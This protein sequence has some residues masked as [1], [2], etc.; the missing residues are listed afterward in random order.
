RGD[1]ETVRRTEAF[2]RAGRL[3]AD[4][5]ALR[6]GDRFAEPVVLAPGADP[7]ALVPGQEVQVDVV[8]RNQG[9]GHT[10]PGGTN[11]SNEGWLELALLD[12]SGRPMAASG[13][14]EGDGYVDGASHF[15]GALLLDGDGKPIER[16]NAQ[17]IR[18]EVYTHAIGPGTAD[19]VRY[20]FQVDPGWAGRTVTLRARLLW[21]KF[22][23]AY[24]EFAYRKN[25]DGFR[26]F[27]AVPELPITE[28]VSDRAHLNVVRR[29]GE[30]ARAQSGR[31]APLDWLRFNDYGIGLLLQGDT[32]AAAWAF[33]KVVEAAPERPDGHR[34]LARA[35]VADGDIDTAIHHLERC[36]EMHPGDPQTA[37]VW[38]K[39]LQEAGR[40]V[41]AAAA[42][43]R[44]LQDFPE[45]RQAWKN[46]GRVRYLSGTREGALEALDRALAID[47]EDR[48]V[49]YHRMLTLRA[50][51]RRK[52]A[53]AA[54]A[55]YRKYQIDESAREVTR[56]FLLEH[57]DEERE[58][59]PIHT[60]T[61]PVWRSDGR[62]LANEAGP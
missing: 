12:E 23:R 57:P 43:E 48:M 26:S 22:D 21:R 60:H 6:T 10:F 27:D 32:R 5:V 38:G 8:V 9:V 11:D 20:R 54:E 14:L 1:A 55:A 56:A 29:G 17:D 42:Y 36:E 15:Y 24:T 33:K 40:Y 49:H 19:V 30:K 50:L 18:A 47:P 52:E 7:P 51:G 41:E 46:L 13:H 35:A 59:Q 34:N 3:R 37:W 4:L 53:V 61:V 28:I 58:S 2:L 45:D 16:R 62:R 39:A 31:P 44:V 25:P